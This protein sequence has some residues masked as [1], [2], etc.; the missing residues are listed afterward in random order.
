MSVS[1]VSSKS[2]TSSAATAETP[3]SWLA[4]HKSLLLQISDSQSPAVHVKLLFI[5]VN[6]G[7]SCI[8]RD[9]CLPWNILQLQCFPKSCDSLDNAYHFSTQKLTELSLMEWER[10]FAQFL[11]QNWHKFD[12][13]NINYRN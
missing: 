12:T 2:E 11:V 7:R 9:H 10:I 1:M 8:R 3:T 6:R 13:F 5:C 4:C